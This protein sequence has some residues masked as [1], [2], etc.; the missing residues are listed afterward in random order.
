MAI[1]PNPLNQEVWEMQTGGTVYVQESGKDRATRVRGKGSRLRINPED[2]Q[3]V[4]ERIRKKQHD[5]FTNGTLVR[6][7]KNQ[8]DDPDTASPSA[9]GD[10]ELVKILTQKQPARFKKSI[11]ELSEIALRRLKDLAEENDVS[12]NQMGAINEVL[13]E[14]FYPGAKEPTHDLDQII[15][16]LKEEHLRR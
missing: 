16:N 14:K 9:K 15:G 1:V 13:R 8:Q 5:P 6:I 7:D 4:Q 11:E 10:L 12:L 2:R 3:L